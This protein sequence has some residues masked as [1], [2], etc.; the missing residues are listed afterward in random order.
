[1]QGLNDNMAGNQNAGT[2]TVSTSEFAAKYR[3]KREV[4]NL[5][6]VDANVYLPAYGK[7]LNPNSKLELRPCLTHL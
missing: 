2:V 7:C 5:L 4:Y 1:M 3:S 6:A